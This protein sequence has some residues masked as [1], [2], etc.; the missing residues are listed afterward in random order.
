M[1]NYLRAEEAAQLALAI[2]AI[3]IQPVSITWWLWPVL[4]LSP[5]LSMLGYLHNTRTGAAAYNLFHH[6]GIAALIILIGYGLH[7]PWMLFIG[8][9]LFA[10]ATFDRL[11]GYGLKYA[12]SFSHTHLDYVGKA[13]I[14]V[15]A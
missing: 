5:D 9:V 7:M 15:Q 12:D 6:K 8:L 2:L 11:A 3:C 4:F 13:K 10:H 1:K 14:P